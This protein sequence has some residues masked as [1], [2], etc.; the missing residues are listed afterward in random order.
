[1]SKSHQKAVAE[2][3]VKSAARLSFSI[4]KEIAA[5]ILKA[6]AEEVSQIRRRAA[7]GRWNRVKREE[8]AA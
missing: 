7:R 4:R 5:L 8:K 6:T 1:M 3:V 2:R